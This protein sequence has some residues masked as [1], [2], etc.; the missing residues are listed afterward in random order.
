MTCLKSF[1]MQN[2]SALTST[3]GSLCIQIYSYAIC[4][5]SLSIYPLQFQNKTEN[6]D[7]GL[8]LKLAFQLDQDE[9]EV[10]NLVSRFALLY[11][12]FARITNVTSCD[13]WAYWSRIVK[14]NLVFS[15]KKPNPPVFWFY[16]FLRFLVF[17]LNLSGFY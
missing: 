7:L 17:F 13:Y 3:L 14:K 5:A 8:P 15:E 1:L 16:G 4:N 11:G 6:S 10:Q 9:V 2:L 12:R